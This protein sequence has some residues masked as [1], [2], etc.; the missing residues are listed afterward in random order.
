MSVRLDP[1]TSFIP[2]IDLRCKND[3]ANNSEDNI[4][5]HVIYLPSTHKISEKVQCPKC[6]RFTRSDQLLYNSEL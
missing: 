1:S 4:N 3:A 5:E 2:F 6:K